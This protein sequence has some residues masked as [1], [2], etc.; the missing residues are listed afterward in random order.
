MQAPCGPNCTAAPSDKRANTDDN[1]N[2]EEEDWSD[3]I[4]QLEAMVSLLSEG[5]GTDPQPALNT[6]QEEQKT[7]EHVTQ[8][9]ENDADANDIQKIEKVDSSV[10]TEKETNYTGTQTARIKQSKNNIY[11]GD[12]PDK[13]PNI[14]QVEQTLAQ[15]EVNPEGEDEGQG[16]PDDDTTG[17]NVSNYDSDTATSEE[18]GTNGVKEMQKEELT[19]KT[20]RRAVKLER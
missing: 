11:H 3:V 6:A 9:E 8:L 10:Q 18:G 15:T 16:A 12:I 4:A 20:R 17:N 2:E 14:A 19:S 13:K 7:T 1:D 5:G